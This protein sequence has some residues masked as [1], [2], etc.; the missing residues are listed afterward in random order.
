MITRLNRLGVNPAD[1]T[2]VWSDALD[3]AKMQEL[4]FRFSRR[5][6]VAFGNGTWLVHDLDG[7]APSNIVMKLTHSNGR[8]VLKVPDSPGKLVNVPQWLYDE[9]VRECGIEP[10]PG[11]WR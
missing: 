1:K 3:F 11:D 6:K 10:L 9:A 2:F 7:I 5:V 4:A 8:P